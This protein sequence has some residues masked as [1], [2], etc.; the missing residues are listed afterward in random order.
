M[1]YTYMYFAGYMS[2]PSRFYLVLPT[3]KPLTW[4]FGTL[5]PDLANSLYLASHYSFNLAAF[6]TRSL[7]L[8]LSPTHFRLIFVANFELV[9]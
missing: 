5:F 7:P 1:P 6:L 2:R 9:S 4:N 3:N 8:A